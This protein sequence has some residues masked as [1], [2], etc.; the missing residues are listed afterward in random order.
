MH[1][2]NLLHHLMMSESSTHDHS[3]DGSENL[4]FQ[5]LNLGKMMNRMENPDFALSPFS[6]DL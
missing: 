5:T 4:L 3:M 6:H 2:Q 1:R